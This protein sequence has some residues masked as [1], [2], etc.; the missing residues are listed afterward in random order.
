VALVTDRFRKLDDLA[1]TR[2]GTACLP[3]NQD[4]PQRG[5]WFVSVS[6]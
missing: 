6:G 3:G 5:A 4:S 1:R 2:R